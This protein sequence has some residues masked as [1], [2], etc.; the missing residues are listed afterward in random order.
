MERPKTIRKLA[1]KR[2]GPGIEE[3]ETKMRELVVL[4]AL[5]SEGDP[6]IGGIKF[7]KLLFYC[8]FLAY[9]TLGNPITGFEYFAL[10]NGP[11]PRHKVG[12]WSKMVARKD[13][14]VRKEPAGLESERE[15]T[16]ALRE[17]VISV[18]S[19]EEI[20]LIYRVVDIFRKF[21]GNDLSQ[22]SHSF[23]GWLLARERETI[24]Y[25]AA[26]IGNRPPSGDE[27]N[28]GLEIERSLASA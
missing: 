16:L 11:A 23:P 7:N 3:N 6:N 18:F 1:N 24:P 20:D 25:S 9:L 22:I 21:T 14:A 19:K 2:T 28:R 17:P 15:I 27:I 12:L 8:D 26:L 4:L 5:R 10:P 13:I